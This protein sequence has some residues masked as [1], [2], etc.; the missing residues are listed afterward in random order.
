MVSSALVPNIDPS[1]GV[2]A[3]SFELSLSK[4]MLRDMLKCVHVVESCMRT[5]CLKES[6]VIESLG[7]PG[8]GVPL[9][10]AAFMS[11]YLPVP[12]HNL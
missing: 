4:C 9:T 11:Y 6:I 1:T 3:T 5:A 10:E 7:A 8:F 2:R 12:G